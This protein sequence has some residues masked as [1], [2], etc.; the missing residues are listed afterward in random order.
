MKNEIYELTTLLQS[1]F[2]K[3]DSEIQ[4]RNTPPSFFRCEGEV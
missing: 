1:E 4:G 2:E 3:L